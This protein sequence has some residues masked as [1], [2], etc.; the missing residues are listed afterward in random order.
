LST[1]CHLCNMLFLFGDLQLFLGL[2]AET[3][4]LPNYSITDW[5]KISDQSLKN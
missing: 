3:C 5:K 1:S 4:Q 2:K